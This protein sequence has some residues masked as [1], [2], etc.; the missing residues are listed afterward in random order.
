M[1]VGV[2][3]IGYQGVWITHNF[4]IEC[5]S[6]WATARYRICQ[7][8]ICQ[9]HGALIGLAGQDPGTHEWQGS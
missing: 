1:F 2:V 3:H 9:P 7:A 4:C 8:D 5:G 6:I